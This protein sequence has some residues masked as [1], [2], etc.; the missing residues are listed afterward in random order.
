MDN[1]NGIRKAPKGL[2]ALALIGPGFVW[3]AEYIGSGEVILATRAG[4]ILGYAVLWAP[5]LGIILKTCIGV[6]GARYTVCTG[7]G[8]VDMFSR[9]PGRR[10]WAVWI[11]LVSMFLAG[12]MAV[13]SAASAAGVFANSLIPLSPFVWGWIIS[14]FAVAVVW[15]GTFDI[16]KYIMSVFVFII[17]VGVLYIAYHTFP[18]I[19]N[20]TKAIFGFQLPSVPEWAIGLDNVSA[21]PWREVLPLVGWAAGG[22]AS[23]VWYTYWIIGAGYGMT[24]GRGYGKPANVESLKTMTP[25]T[26]RNVKGWCRI[27][28]M[29][30][31]VA[32]IIGLVVT[33]GFVIAGSGILRPA[34][35]APDGTALAFE[36]SNIFSKVWGKAG[37]ILFIIAGWAALTSTTICHLA[38][39]PRLIADSLRICFPAFEKRF[40]WRTQFKMLLAI[41]FTTNII[42][43]Y[44][45]GIN[46]VFIVKLSAVLEGLLFTP[47]QAVLVLIGLMW[48]LPKLLSKESWEILR[49]HWILPLGLVLAVIVFGYFCYFQL[50]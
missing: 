48:V 27:V 11:V 20:I 38:G 28:Y 44:S 12:S 41:F 49:P 2:L 14:L 46:P 43:V 32:M 22:F 18:G 39:W 47:L 42:I 33:S 45:F 17:V 37:G 23:Q 35:I 7:E 50:F 9:M 26:A 1:K 24:E 29:D 19:G 5:I 30:A 16:M 34:Q 4:A 13:G 36:L 31:T 40:K 21:N 8:M 10:N 15:S 3:S 6:S 25:K